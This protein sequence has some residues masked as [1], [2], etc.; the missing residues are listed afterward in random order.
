MEDGQRGAQ[1]VGRF[2]G[3]SSTRAPAGAHGRAGREHGGGAGEELGH[4]RQRRVAAQTV[5][6]QPR[7]HERDQHQGRPPAGEEPA[8]GKKRDHSQHA[9]GGPGTSPEVGCEQQ[10]LRGQQG[11]PGQ[12]PPGQCLVATGQAHQKE[13]SRGRDSGGD[14]DDARGR[15]AQQPADFLAEGG[16][17]S[18]EQGRPDRGRQGDAGGEHAVPHS[19]QPTGHGDRDAHARYVT[20]DQDRPGAPAA[21]ALLGSVEASLREVQEA[22]QRVREQ[23][24]PERPG[25]QVQV[26][27]AQRDGGDQG[28]PGGDPGQQ[29]VGQAVPDVE[30]ESVARHQQRYARFLY[31]EQEERAQVALAFERSGT[32]KRDVSQPDDRRPAG[33]HHDE[34]DRDQG[35]PAPPAHR[36][37]RSRTSLPPMNISA[38]PASGFTHQKRPI[39]IEPTS[40]NA[41]RQQAARRTPPA[42]TAKRWPAGTPAATL[43]MAI[44]LS[45]CSATSVN[46]IKTI[47]TRMLRITVTSY[48]V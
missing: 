35:Q 33:S 21:E 27:R 46:A 17:Q 14:D 24:T 28:Q 30:D 4:H 26:G 31:V 43:E 11:G 22:R 16:A 9:E 12:R 48:S 34:G 47:E 6:H 3:Q 15:L 8:G 23:T 7:T 10:A 13:G 38:S 40:V 36:G 45:S 18:Q 19:Q 37:S 25:D 42:S 5:V 32:R 39:R 2:S 1:I 29:R 41:S 20:S 44:A